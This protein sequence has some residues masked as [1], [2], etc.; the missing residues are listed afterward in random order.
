M[1]ACLQI[2]VVQ[3]EILQDDAFSPI[4]VTKLANAEHKHK[5]PEAAEKYKKDFQTIGF[6]EISDHVDTK[7]KECL[8]Q[9][10][11]S[12]AASRGVVPKIIDA[13]TIAATTL[14][15]EP[16]RIVKSLRIRSSGMRSLPCT[17]VMRETIS[18][19]AKRR[20]LR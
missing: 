18:L 8:I 11:K 5:L 6:Y 17:L 9:L 3:R 20:S 15:I 19:T 10:F 12:N 16:E 13:L 4:L 7:M 1:E 2:L 14:N